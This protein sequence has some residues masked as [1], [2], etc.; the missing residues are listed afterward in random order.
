MIEFSDFGYFWHCFQLV[1]LGVFIGWILAWRH[2]EKHGSVGP[3]FVKRDWPR[4]GE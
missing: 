2:Y 4:K 1:V 3:P